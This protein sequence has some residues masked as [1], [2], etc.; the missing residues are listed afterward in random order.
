MAVVWHV[1]VLLSWLGQV[2]VF[3]ENLDFPRSYDVIITS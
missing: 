2:R 3:E 1:G